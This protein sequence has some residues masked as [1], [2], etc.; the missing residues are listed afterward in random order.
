GAVVMATRP[1]VSLKSCAPLDFSRVEFLA[2]RRSAS[3]ACPGAVC[4][5]GGGIE[6]GET[7]REAARREF[8]EEIGVDVAIGCFLAENRT[9]SGG[10]LFWFVGEILDA[11]AEIQIEQEEVAAY[12]WRTL[13]DLTNDPD[14][15]PNNLEIMRQI[16]SGEISM[17]D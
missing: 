16:L 12:E 2:I 8:R 15:L 10:R 5:P 17:L 6:P 3:V 1:G 13:V 14:F 4:F 7:P 11:D 9:P